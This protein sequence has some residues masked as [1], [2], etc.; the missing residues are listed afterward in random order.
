[1][2]NT[3]DSDSELT[4]E[5]LEVLQDIRQETVKLREIELAAIPPAIVFE[6]G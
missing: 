5:G 3:T 6:A 1:M 2:S 4:P